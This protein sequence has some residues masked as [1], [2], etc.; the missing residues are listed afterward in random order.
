MLLKLFLSVVAGAFVGLDREIK[1]K[2]TGIR[3]SSI[4]CMGT[5]LFTILAQMM[6]A[7]YIDRGHLIANLPQ[8][9]GF[10]CAGAILRQDKH[11]FGLTSAAVLWALGGIGV[12]IGFGYYSLAF[13]STILTVAVVTIVD[14][15]KNKGSFLKNKIGKRR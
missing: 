9:L 12:A 7:S 15:F 1:G 11:V 3:T 10:L 6:P 2:P 4:V 5:C 8:G 13:T 14:H